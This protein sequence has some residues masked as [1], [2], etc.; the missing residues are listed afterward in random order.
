M[1]K[2]GSQGPETYYTNTE[3]PQAEVGDYWDN[4]YTLRVRSQ[5]RWITVA[6]P[7]DVSVLANP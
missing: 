4:G 7:S 2:A 6:G 5:T 3:P 1:P